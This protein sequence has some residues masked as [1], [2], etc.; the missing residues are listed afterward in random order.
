MPERHSRGERHKGEEAAALPPDAAEPL[1]VVPVPELE[2]GLQTEPRPMRPAPR[3][4][5]S[6]PEL[7]RLQKRVSRPVAAKSS[8][9]TIALLIAGGAVAAFCLM[10]VGSI[11]L[12]FVWSRIVSLNATPT[13]RGQDAPIV[14][15]QP[16]AN[17]LE[18]AQEWNVQP[19]QGQ[20]QDWNNKLPGMP[21]GGVPAA[22]VQPQFPR[23]VPGGILCQ[24]HSGPV[25]ALAFTPDGSTLVSAGE[26]GT[27]KL[28]EAATG[29]E[30]RTIEA[31]H[32]DAI[33][34]IALSPDRK[35]LVVASVGGLLKLFDLDT[36]QEKASMEVI[37]RGEIALLLCM[38][39][40]PDGKT[41]ALGLGTG[42][43]RLW[44]TDTRRMRAKWKGEDR[45]IFSLAF[46]PDGR[47]L[48]AATDSLT[49]NLWDMTQGRVVRT[50]KGHAPSKAPADGFRAPAWTLKSIQFSPDGKTLATASNDCLVK[51]WDVASGKERRTLRHDHPVLAVAFSRDGQFLVSATCEGEVRLWSAAS[52]KAQGNMAPPRQPFLILPEN[53][54]IPIRALAFSPD[55]KTVAV[56]RG[57][58]VELRD[59]AQAF[60]KVA[61]QPR[62]PAAVPPAAIR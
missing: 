62:P 10:G 9:A 45:M 2:E 28:W 18:R 44:D 5:G 20:P 37:K 34:S 61:Q 42:E 49:V 29:R 17:A 54:N 58:Q 55:G 30:K 16:D 41:V 7:V 13:A 11:M 1:E 43:I 52:G 22:P 15:E 24:G 60:I 8:G 21:G 56:G 33:A 40:A 46:S 31:L 57:K 51:L 12:W 38:A 3:P 27:V 6:E 39:L 53:T 23:V 4:R 19:G 32:K 14:V 36:G 25:V 48:A 59:R 47:T 35:T 50:L 26:D